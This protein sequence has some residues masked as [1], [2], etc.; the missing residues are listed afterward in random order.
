[1]HNRS[2]LLS[3]T[4]LNA[5]AIAEMDPGS[6]M[7]EEER[8]YVIVPEVVGMVEHHPMEHGRLMAQTFHLGRVV[9]HMRVRMGHRL[10]D[11]TTIVLAVRNSRELAKVRDELVYQQF[12]EMSVPDNKLG[13]LP[14]TVY[15]DHNPDVY[16][17]PERVLTAI[18]VGP[19]VKSRVEAC[20]GH[21]ELY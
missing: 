2:K 15:E 5:G 16:L 1:M 10:Q 14:I 11:I 19:V 12:S 21:L 4:A 13:M 17:T 20:L 3:E 9:E 8:F 6:A 18:S 7:K